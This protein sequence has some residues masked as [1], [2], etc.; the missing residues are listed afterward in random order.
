MFGFVWGLVLWEETH[1]CLSMSISIDYGFQSK[2]DDANDCTITGIFFAVLT[3]TMLPQKGSSLHLYRRRQRQ[4]IP[5][6]SWSLELIFS[7]LSMRYSL[8]SMTDMN[9]SMNHL[10]TIASYQRW[11]M[12]L[13]N[14]MPINN[15][16]WIFLTRRLITE[17]WRY[18]TLWVH[19]GRC[20]QHVLP[21]NWK[22]KAQSWS[23]EFNVYISNSYHHFL[24]QTV[25]LSVDLSAASAAEEWLRS[26]WNS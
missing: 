15:V 18:D 20:T 19:G 6:P 2:G 5:S 9:R 16:V 8:I 10:W 11:V 1:I 24:E 17:L 26:S 4:S 25:D 14:D 23:S 22:G 3:L 12:S 7:G 13:L 21:D